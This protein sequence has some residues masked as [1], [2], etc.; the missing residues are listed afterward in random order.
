MK[1]CLF[2]FLLLQSTP[3]LAQTWQE[4]YKKADSLMQ[5]RDFNGAV[6]FYEQVLPLIQKDSTKKSAAYLNARNGLGR[7]M[8]F[9]G[10]KEKAEAFLLENID[11]AKS[12]GEKT[13]AYGTAL[14]N[15]GS[16]YSPK[17][18]GN[19][20]KK[21][22]EF[23][24][25]SIAVRE[26]ALG[27]KHLD[28]SSSL[29]SLGIL[30]YDMN[31][32]TAA[33]LIYKQVIQIRREVV[34]EKHASYAAALNNLANLYWSMG[35]YSLSEPIYKQAMQIRREVLGEKHL[36]YIVS[37]SNLAGFYLAT[38]NYSAAEPLYKQVAQIRKEIL[39]EK[40]PSYA[41]A[42]NNL[43]NLY[44]NMGYYSASEP[45][46]KQAMQIRKDILGEK[47][48][49]YASSINGLSILYYDMGNYV[50]A[51]QLYK[52]AL[53]IQKEVFGE[54]HHTYATSL[55][56]L[57][58]LYLAMGNYGAAEPLY[59]Q[60]MQ[61]RKEVLGE[62]HPDYAVSLNNLAL[63]YEKNAEY[64]AAVPL[65]KQAGHI[66]KDIFGEKHPDYAASLNNL[67]GLYFAM[68]NYYAAESLYKQVLQIRKEVLG[69]K[70]PEYL[71]LMGNFAIL[72]RNIRNYSLAESFLNEAMQTQKE[73]L[74]ENHPNYIFLLEAQ[75]LLN[76]HLRKKEI[77]YREFTHVK[78]WCVKQTELQ[79][80]SLSEVQKEAFYNQKVKQYLNIY[81]SLVIEMPKINATELYDLQL[82]TKA[83]LMQASQKI[84]NRIL[85]SGD[86]ALIQKYW[87]WNT[88]KQQIIK[89]NEM[90][91]KERQEKGIKL[92]SLG[93]L[94]ETLEKNL[95]LKSETFASLTDKKSTSWQDIQKT[96]KKGEAA[97]E[98]VRINKYGV[99]RI[100]TDT[101]DVTQAPI[102]PQYPLWGLTDTIYYAALILKKNSKQP[103]IV[104][105]KNGN[106][107]EEK[108]AVY[109]KNT[110]QFMQ[111]DLISYDQFWKPIAQNLKGIKKVFFSPDGIYN[112][113]SL[114]T[115]Q[116]PKTKK[117]VLDEI[118]LHLVT[119]TKDI[120]AF[121]KSENKTLKAELLGYPLYDL[122]TQNADNARM[123]EV[124]ADSTRAFANFQ[125]VSLLPGTK[126][127]VETIYEILNKKNYQTKV[128]MEK[129]A[130]EE[131][132]KK[133]KNPKILHLSTH[134]FFIDSKEK[135]EK[136]NP[137]LR[138][139]L[140]LTGVSD[141]TRA[142]VKPDT[143]DGILTALEAANL[144][145]DETDLV[146]LSACETGLGDVK[147]GEGVY[148]LQRAFKVAGAKSIV[149][150]MWK[151]DDA[152]TQKLMTTFYQKFAESNKARQAF[153]EAQAII[154]KQHPEP[155]YWGAFVMVGE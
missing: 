65:Y 47:H 88:L 137:M 44:W 114:N 92:D 136:V 142:E 132:I 87:E 4:T 121:G 61:I 143:E 71:S 25:Q 67:A 123:R 155:Y 107:L 2:I 80:P 116:N 38:S 62:K 113:I 75:A 54:K 32:Y 83:L 42:L 26:E 118:E 106:E 103:K 149:M 133:V 109:Q 55:N 6:Q 101:S 79:L 154:K 119:N 140:L 135:N 41:A 146:V 21:S 9:V 150:S 31:N 147:A 19:N 100:I 99:H 63:F 68:G 74:G 66:L 45:L 60:A 28:Y 76:W 1:Y 52:Q 148:G 39:G 141:Y 82:S 53:Q 30:Y 108:F 23:I 59:K 105:L 37:V 64:N 48:P 14:Q 69:E 120:L 11:L 20:P 36:D 58:N 78:N 102:S 17:G 134:G 144:D 95:S 46:Y 112:Q 122:Q 138:S 96:L 73:V 153:K 152:V 126:K 97:I 10:E 86:T 13:A 8:T 51:E 145:L 18:K 124:L 15:A 125:Q 90:S 34:G 111:E 50:A 130:T 81:S 3:L 24:K 16:F 7:C 56:N 57:A 117:F 128:L 84:K 104:L 93:E 131:N 129:S 89:V 40:H 110:I 22:E 43:A 94:S 127:E 5:K 139:G 72:Y 91:Q 27:T 33:E 77:A 70:H 115:L 49:D 35:K 12:F 85:N 151:V 29:T 98:I